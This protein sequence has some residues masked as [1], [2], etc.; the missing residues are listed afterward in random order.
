[1]SK[2]LLLTPIAWDSQEES[3]LVRNAIASVGIKE[4]CDRKV[5]YRDDPTLCVTKVGTFKATYH[6]FEKAFE[7]V[8]EEGLFRLVYAGHRLIRTDGDKN[9]L[10]RWLMMNKLSM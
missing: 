4:K 10:K 6:S 1:M 3:E 9:A 5:R 8:C 7:I 2:P